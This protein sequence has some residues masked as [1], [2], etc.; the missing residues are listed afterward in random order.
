M[1]CALGLLLFVLRRSLFAGKVAALGARLQVTAGAAHHDFDPPVV[2]GL[3]GAW[4]IGQIV[5]VANVAGDLL[6]DGFHFIKILGK[7]S[8]STGLQRKRFKRPFGAVLLA[9]S[10]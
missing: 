9:L 1:G 6:A 3:R 2:D 10:A 4:R 5:L 8:D 7:E